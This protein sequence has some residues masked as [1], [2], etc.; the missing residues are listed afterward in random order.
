[1]AQP[2]TMP[3]ILI[4]ELGAP[5]TVAE[6]WK[7]LTRDGQG[8][9]YIACD[10][11]TTGLDHFDPSFHIRMIQFGD[12]ESGW[13]LPFQDWK[14]LVFGALR[15]LE[16]HRV[17]IVW[18]NLAFDAQALHHEGYKLDM[19]LQE[20][21]FV[22]ASLGGFAEDSR[23]LKPT[24]ARELGQWVLF[25]QGLLKAGMSNAGWGWDSVPLNWRPYSSYG[26]IDT[27]VT[28]MLREK[29]TDRRAKY[30]WHHSLEIATID[31][32]N[33][34]ERN[35]FA[36]DT[37]YCL[38]KLA[39]LEQA[40]GDIELQLKTH[41]VK[42]AGQNAVVAAVLQEAGVLPEVLKMTESGQISM[43]KHVLSIVDHPVAR[44]VL[45][46]R[47]IAK[48]ETYLNAMITAAQGSIGPREMAHASIRSIEAKTGRMCIPTSHSV[49]TSRG[50]LSCDSVA[51]GDLTLDKDNQWTTVT[52]V[53]RYKAQ[54][55]VIL[56]NE[57]R[58]LQFTAEHRWVTS[59]EGNPGTTFVEKLGKARRTIHLAPEGLNPFSVDYL[60]TTP[61][62]REAALIGCLATDGRCVW[63]DK[64]QVGMRAFLYQT[65]RKFYQYMVSLIPDGMLSY[66]RITIND[67]HEM[68]LRSKQLRTLLRE[69]GLDLARGEIL[70]EKPEL[71]SWVLGL[72]AL[73]CTSFLNA[74]WRCDGRIKHRPYLISCDS[75]NLRKTIA[76]AA[77][78]CG[79]SSHE[80]E[81]AASE[82]GTKPRVSVVVTGSRMTTRKAA[83]SSGVSD[84]WCVSTTSG[85]FTAWDNDHPYLTG[86]S[87]SKP[88][89]QQM[90]KSDKDPTVRNAVV[91]REEGHV[92]VGADFGQ[93]ELRM[94]ASITKDQALLGV[95]NKLDEEK[96][97]GN[98]EADFFVIL[99]KDLYG[100]DFQ[101]SDYRR[102]MLKTTCVPLSTPILTKRGWLTH[103][104]VQIG[105][106]T[107]GYNQETGLSEWTK[108]THVHRFAQQPLVRMSHSHHFTA[109]TTP[110]HRWL[111]RHRS[112][113]RWVT[114]ESVKTTDNLI[115][116]APFDGPGIP[117][118]DDEAAL[119]GWILSDGYLKVFP[120][121]GS[122]Q[123][124]GGDRQQVKASISQNAGASA[125]AIQALLGGLQPYSVTDVHRVWTIPSAQ[126]RDLCRRSGLLTG[127]GARPDA[128][129]FVASLSQEQRRRMLES[130]QAADGLNQSSKPRLTSGSEGWKSEFYRYLV[131]LS[132]YRTRVD[133]RSPDGS[134]WAKNPWHITIG[135]APTVTGQRLFREDSGVA[136]VWCVTTELGSWTME[137]GGVQ[138]IT[139]N[140]Y[141]KLYSGGED[142]IA[143]AAKVD[144]AV[145]S[146]VIKALEGKYASFAT[147]GD[148]LITRDQAGWHVSTPTGRPF[149]VH[150]QGERR[151]LMNYLVQGHSAEILKMALANAEEAGLGEYFVLPVH[152][153]LILSVPESM[154]EEA[155][156]ELV[157]CMDAVV[158]PDA[159][160]V[161]VSASPAD[162]AQRWGLMDH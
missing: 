154:A 130:V 50:V 4:S 121:D 6:F 90:P 45:Q 52:A 108:V 46:Y 33:R 16:D 78:R 158:D 26:V 119:L 76:I 142:T 160:G 62:E 92:L 28:A 100:P 10:T 79:F 149:A 63:P 44:L 161:K 25:G 20:D 77:Y 74:V 86:N 54:D 127:D 65:E 55:I 9:E 67:H 49:L 96:A 38:G 93:I 40:R 137:Q 75:P 103:D 117:V 146:K 43:D 131:A 123:Q 151:K 125:D 35:G 68:R 156:R 87:I 24:G 113:L 134:G 56:S 152:D 14:G 147:L 21:T 85:T 135:Q 58:N 59:M 39:E 84:V 105:D 53:H 88:A 132:G 12:A 29:W 118:T 42:S 72:T 115:V 15:W 36:V 162:P 27:V 101:K 140:C 31:S 104:Q 71:I 32:T 18:H 148:E 122:R 64:D 23:A 144:P 17:R 69:H 51:V 1:M 133:V 83:V 2:M 66:D 48:T 30:G 37:E 120:L 3:N 114:T 7:W 81:C 102:N 106:E 139:G 157:S 89:L 98:K 109:V 41:G 47:G 126:A 95:L 5:D 22:W 60:P 153:E 138:L 143:K 155:T 94:F 112:G 91:P 116:A 82:W 159:Y 73:E 107:I 57:T 129:T 124:A 80:S 61:K 34:M 70:R 141:A 8:R 11:E 19:S 99:G 97:A 136:D 145:I 13:A 150:T 128:L 110:N 111:S